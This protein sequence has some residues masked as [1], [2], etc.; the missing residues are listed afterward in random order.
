MDA[1]VGANA[2]AALLD[3]LP[4][5]DFLRWEIPA[6]QVGAV[7]LAEGAAAFT[8]R[9]AYNGR[10]WLFAVGEGLSVG[11]VVV[12][13]LGDLPEPGQSWSGC[14]AEDAS[15]VVGMSVPPTVFDVLAEPWRPTRYEDY[16][17]WILDRCPPPAAG[18]DRVLEVGA[19]D[20]RLAALVSHSRSAYL[21]PGDRRARSWFAVEAAATPGS[22]PA[23]GAGGLLACLTYEEHKPGVPHLASVVVDPTA[24]RRGAGLALCTAVSRQLLT[25]GAGAVTL[26]MYSANRPAAALYQRIGFRA[27][28]RFKAGYIPGRGRPRRH[29]DAQDALDQGADAPIQPTP[30]LGASGEGS[31][32]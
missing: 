2:Y 27:A 29:D 16:T 18:E 9:N 7:W 4:G 3:A 10:P 19:D 11:D 30:G 24:R 1:I 22:A 28:G 25:D 20:P 6:E 17:W 13:A 32:G 15:C 12:E 5:N 14:P 8:A 23:A 26:A 31:P 21:L